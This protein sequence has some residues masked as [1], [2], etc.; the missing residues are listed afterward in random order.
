[1]EFKLP[2]LRPLW[3]VEPGEDGTTAVLAEL[4]ELRT[5]RQVRAQV[6]TCRGKPPIGA[7]VEP[8]TGDTLDMVDW[9][10][11]WPSSRT[12]REAPG[13]ARRSSGEPPHLLRMRGV[14]GPPD[15]EADFCRPQCRRAFNNRRAVRGAE[16]YDLVMAH[17]FDRA[18]A[19]DLGV[20][21]LINRAASIFREEDRRERG[22]RPR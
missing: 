16:L 5:I 11:A 9:I 8:R 1:M 3:N 17:R 6:A 15:R 2:R 22:G 7:T 14:L 21:A 19:R 20:L 4:V 10:K 13:L 12:A 18:T